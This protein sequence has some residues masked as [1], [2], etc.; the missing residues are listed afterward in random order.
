MKTSEKLLRRYEHT[1]ESCCMCPFCIDTDDDEDDVL[2]DV[3]III[4]YGQGYDGDDV[5]NKQWVLHTHFKEQL[6]I[7]NGNTRI[8]ED[9]GEVALAYEMAGD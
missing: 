1:A 4:R 8:W 2:A 9:L 7:D 5:W 6:D 3:A